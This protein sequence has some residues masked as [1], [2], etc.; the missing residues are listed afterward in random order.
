MKKTMFLTLLCGSLLALTAG[1]NRNT[2]TGSKLTL[3]NYDQ[4]TN[5]MTKARSR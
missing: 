3:S 2:L 4:V 5:G 1:C